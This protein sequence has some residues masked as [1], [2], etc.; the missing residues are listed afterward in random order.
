MRTETRHSLILVVGT[1]TTA[2]LSMVYSVYAGRMLGP[3]DYADF[4]AAISLIVL[5]SLALGPINGIVTRFTAQF[6]SRGEYGK[7]RT[8]SREISKRVALFGLIGVLIG[9]LAVRPLAGVLQFNSPIPLIMAYGLTYLSLLLNVPRGVLRGVQAF[10]KYSVNTVLEATI[11][12]IAGIVLLQCICGVVSGLSAYLI[13]LTGILVF[14]RF[15]MRSIWRGHAA[16]SVDGSAIRRFTAPMF[17]L[18][19]CGASFQ[20]IDMLF[21]KHYFAP[22]DAGHYGA[23]FTLTRTI[24]MLV[25]PFGLLLLPVIAGLYDRGQPIA[26][27]FARICS[28]FLLL[29][30]G[31]LLL[32]WLWPDKIIVLLYGSEYEAAAPLL[33]LLATARLAGYLAALLE[34]TQSAMNNFRFLY[35]H[36]FTLAAEALALM[37]WHDSLQMIVGVVFVIQGLRLVTMVV[38]T[39]YV[40]RVQDKRST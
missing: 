28:Y 31:P 2:L 16:E 27:P 22:A 1:G 32:F 20:N 11:R 29:V 38:F 17:V 25:T 30:T 34:L 37:I 18:A 21:V 23:A 3:A 36:V 40:G 9:L 14:A 6:A 5:F 26:A 8:L 15:Q 19:L 12:L 35:I 4:T 24:G 39:M 33:G 7:I 13:A 10:G